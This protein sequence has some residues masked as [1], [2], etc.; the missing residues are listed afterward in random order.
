M[1]A[2]TGSPADDPAS[3]GV[4][5]END[6]D[7]PRP[8]RDI[9]E[10]RYPQHV[11][12]RRTELPV[13][14][15]E[16]AWCCLVADGGAHRLAADHASQA[17]QPHQAGDDAA[18]DVEPFAPQLPP[19][20][21]HALDAEVLLEHAAHLQAKRIVT[22]SPSRPSGRLNLLGDV[23]VIGRRGDRRD[24]TDRL[25]PA[26]RAMHIDEGDH[27]FSGRSSSAIAKY[28]EALRRISLAWR[29]SRFS[30]SSAFIRSTTSL[31]T[32]A[33]ISL[34]TS[35]FFTHS[36]SAW[37]AHPILAAIDTAAGQRDVCS[38]SRSSTIRT[39]RAR[40]SGEN[41]FVVLLVIA[42]SSQELGPP[43][44]PARFKTTG[45]D[46]QKKVRRP[47]GSGSN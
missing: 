45:S 41:L 36:C 1:R 10:V 33:R 20:L 25:D 16:R 15:V 44:N 21:A 42:P 9:G 39:A 5:D 11:R 30:R 19:D 24:P 35:A 3:V 2:P 43:T 28:A 29:G 17:H 37:L 14:P 31:C 27:R 22:P 18:G 38:F 4:D 23:R 40:T 47:T 12:R 8:R 6:V 46:T 34:P 7:E 32:P 13:D 26:N